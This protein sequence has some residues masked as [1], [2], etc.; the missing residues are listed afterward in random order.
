MDNQDKSVNE[1]WA[2]PNETGERGYATDPGFVSSGEYASRDYDRVDGQDYEPRSG[3]AA[4]DRRTAEIR[5]DIDRTR[6]DLG[7]TLD[8]IQERLHPG[9]MVSRAAQSAKDTATGKVRQLGR[10]MRGHQ[11]ST[12]H[13]PDYSLNGFVDR[14][15]DNPVPAAIAAASLAWLAFGGRGHR[16]DDTSD[17]MSNAI[18]G[19][20]RGGEPHIRE[21]RI[22]VTASAEEDASAEWKGQAEHAVGRAASEVRETAFV[23]RNRGR[24]FANRS[25]V[26]AGMLAA[27]AGVAIGLMLPE[28][29]REN[30]LMGDARD[31]LVERGREKVKDAAHQVQRVASDVTDAAKHIGGGDTSRQAGNS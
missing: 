11:N 10:A 8:A 7:E 19:T 21:A 5:R 27:A 31:S 28:T 13:G 2:R 3:D 4:T 6:D 16:R 20:T 30:E 1:R 23:A 29:E 22:D 15:R 14:V 25:P 12:F 9:T 17:D 26:A 24:Q 18:Y